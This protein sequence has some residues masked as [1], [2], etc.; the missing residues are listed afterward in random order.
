MKEVKDNRFICTN[1][2]LLNEYSIGWSKIPFKNCTIKNRFFRKKIWNQYLWIG[3]DF[4]FDFTIVNLDYVTAVFTDFYDLKTKQKI[5]KCILYNLSKSIIIDD[6]I[7]SYVHY[8]DKHRFINVLRVNNYLNVEFKW[9]E[10]DVTASINLD[11]ESI[12]ALIPWTYKHFHY[13][14]KHTNLRTKGT[15]TIDNKKYN[16]D[17][18]LVFIDYGRGVWQRKKE[19]NWLTSGFTDEDGKDIGI[20][21][22]AKYTDATGVN[23]NGIKIDDTVYKIYD[24][25]EFIYNKEVNIWNIKSKKTDEVNLE[26][27][28]ILYNNKINNMIVFKS[29]L[30]Q[31]TGYLNGVVKLRGKEIKF[32]NTIGWCEDNFAKW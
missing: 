3:K 29:S 32:N 26:F 18:S 24:D 4:A 16:L 22:G 25:V 28:P 12:N 30:K 11:Y 14:S 5:N 23:E 21:L 17:N 13:T 20:N 9:D 1:E 31:Y 10:I 27:S 2:G 8:K 7:N 6:K 15:L 19:W